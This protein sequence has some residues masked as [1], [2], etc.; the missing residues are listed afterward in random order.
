MAN[1]SFIWQYIKKPGTT[2]A[3]LP[4]SKYLA[5]KMVAE[6]DFERAKCIVEY[7]PGTGV[8]TQKLLEKRR[9]NTTI[10]LIERNE[11]FC[12][13]LREKYANE[14]NFH[15]IEDS[16][17]NTGEHLQKHGFTQADFIISGLPFASLPKEVSANIL[18]QTV[19]FLNPKGRFITFQYTLFKKKIFSQLFAHIDITREFRNVPPAYVLSCYGGDSNA[20]S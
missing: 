4:S 18:T 13:T 6:I 2:G 9:K 15:I 7:G 17:E 19:K 20:I 5:A 10:I 12:A 8:F 14:K 11:N 3:I 16:A 1:L